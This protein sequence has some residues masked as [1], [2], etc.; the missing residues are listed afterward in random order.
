MQ[1]H[2]QRYSTA[3]ILM[4]FFEFY[5]N[6]FNPEDHMINVSFK[7]APILEKEKCCC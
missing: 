5:S 4:K 3:Y 1:Y 2:N 6:E 7:N